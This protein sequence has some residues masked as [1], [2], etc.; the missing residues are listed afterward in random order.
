MLLYSQFHMYRGCQDYIDTTKIFPKAIDY[1]LD[2]G[3]AVKV[4][5]LVSTIEKLLPL[6]YKCRCVHPSLSYEL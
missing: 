6:T 5:L 4:S 1:I 2:C 3:A